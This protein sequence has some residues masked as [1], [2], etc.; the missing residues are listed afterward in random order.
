LPQRIY[1]FENE[2]VGRFDLFIVPIGRG[3]EGIRY[4]A[5]FNR[6]IKPAQAD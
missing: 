2:S 5:A 1:G 4:Q 3:A 6:L